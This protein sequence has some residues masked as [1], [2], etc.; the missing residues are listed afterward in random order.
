MTS[1]GQKLHEAERAVGLGGPIWEG[2]TIEQQARFERIGVAF[3]CRLSYDQT[4]Q[5]VLAKVQA[6]IDRI[7]EHLPDVRPAGGYEEGTDA[8]YASAALMAIESA[9]DELEAAFPP[10]S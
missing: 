4:I 8:D 9:L 7:R 2:L 6:A 3:C 1:L 5:A 10:P